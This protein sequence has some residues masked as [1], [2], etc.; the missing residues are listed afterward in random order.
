MVG[1]RILESMEWEKIPQQNRHRLIVLLGI[2]SLKKLRMSTISMGEA[3]DEQR[4]KCTPEYVQWKGSSLSLRS[5]GNRVYKA[6][7]TATGRTA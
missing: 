2:I 3:N 1:V 4:E 7:N 5:Y 6:V